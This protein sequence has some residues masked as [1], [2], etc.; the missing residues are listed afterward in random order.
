MKRIEMGDYY[1]GSINQGRLYFPKILDP[2]TIDILMTLSLIENQKYGV[3][4]LE[5]TL[6]KDEV[7]PQK[8]TLYFEDGNY[9][10]MLLDYDDEGYIDVRTPYNPDAPKGVFQ[11]MLG[12]PYGATSIVQDIELVKKCFIE[13][14]QTGSVS[15]DLLN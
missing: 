6:A 15:R 11:N 2:N 3:L 13:F 5:N 4:E 1:S 8:L 9:L 14:N 10:L 12:E 7:E